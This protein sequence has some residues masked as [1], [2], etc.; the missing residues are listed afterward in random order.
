LTYQLT[1]GSLANGDTFSGALTRVTGEN[2][3]AYAIQQGTLTAGTNYALTY[4]GAD[5]TITAGDSTVAVT[6]SANPAPTGANVTFTATLSAV[7]PA[8]GTPGGTVQFVVDGS[9]YGAPAALSSGV[10]SL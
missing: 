8:I 5:L 3:G 2:A 9:A 6:S 7:S 1:S 4:V 10:A